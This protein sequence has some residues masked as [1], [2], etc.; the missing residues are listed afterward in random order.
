LQVFY[1]HGIYGVAKKDENYN[2]QSN[3]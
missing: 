2:E 3:R 1:P